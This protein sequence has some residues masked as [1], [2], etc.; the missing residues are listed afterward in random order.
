MNRMIVVCL[1]LLFFVALGHDATAVNFTITVN[2]KG[3]GKGVVT[4][5]AGASTIINCGAG[6]NTCSNSVLSGSQIALTAT[7]QPGFLFSGW[8][9][10]VGSTT[11]CTG[12]TRVCNITLNANSA[13]TASFEPSSLS[14]SVSI[15]GNQNG[16]VI[17]LHGQSGATVINC[18]KG[19]PGICS[20]TQPYGAQINLVPSTGTAFAVWSNGIGSASICNG[21]TDIHCNVVLN[22][23][24]SIRANFSPLSITVTVGGPGNVSSTL[25]TGS[26]IINCG[27]GGSQCTNTVTFNSNV[28]LTPT[29]AARASFVA[30]GNGTG[31]TSVCNGKNTPCTFTV[32]ADS[33][34]S[35]QFK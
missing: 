32:N 13:I 4:G 11:A 33:S 9:D 22:Q 10:Q 35:A 31:S 12:T 16:Q 15:G 1:L 6:A 17:G 34:V 28:T 25:R 30:W 14:F 29:A 24:S 26:T 27:N 7:S 2:V 19:G 23:N 21:K 18:G 3:S 20:T 8:S 5:T